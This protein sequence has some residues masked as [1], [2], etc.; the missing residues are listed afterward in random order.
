MNAMKRH[1]F[2]LI[3]SFATLAMMVFSCRSA[4][5]VVYL[6]DTYTEE[7]QAIKN[8][9]DIRIQ[10]GDMLSIF[11][12]HKEPTLSA[13]FNPQGTSPTG[14]STSLGQRLSGYTVDLEGNIDFPIVGRI[15]VAGLTRSELS[16]MISKKLDDDGLLKGAVV[17]VAYQNFNI[18]VLGEVNHP[19]KFNVESDRV[20]LFDAL[21]M[22]GDLT[23]YGRRDS[24]MVIR[25]NNGQR[26]IMYNNLLSKDVLNSPSYF[27]QQND[28]VYVKPNHVKAQQSGINQNNNV[29]VWL[30]AA[31]LLTTILMFMF[32]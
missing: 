21:A 22:A 32:K 13:L 11:V 3:L 8:F 29:G 25:E 6:Q 20:S 4:K 27:L 10:P 17:T 5:E 1:G 26:Q 16:T 18:S 19:G 31:S 30:S 7:T 2:L 9:Q 24:V 23:I 28:V 12:S 15:K 14:S